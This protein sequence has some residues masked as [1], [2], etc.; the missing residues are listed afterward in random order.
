VYFCVLDFGVTVVD[1]SILICFGLAYTTGLARLAAGW[2]LVL[3][4]GMDEG[5]V[6]VV[7]FRNL[8]W[9]GGDGDLP[10]CWNISRSM[11]S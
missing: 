4:V 2:S 1:V 9:S 6:L 10:S 7:R 11:F 3:V 5:F 8:D